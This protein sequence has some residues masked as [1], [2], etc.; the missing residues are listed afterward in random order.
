MSGSMRRLKRA[1]ASSART[2]VQE[3]QM[4]AGQERRTKSSAISNCASS[5]PLQTNKAKACR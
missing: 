5:G 2:G 4:P 1:I 3:A